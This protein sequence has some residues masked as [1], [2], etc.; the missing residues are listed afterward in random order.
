MDDIVMRYVSSTNSQAKLAKYG[1]DNKNLSAIFQKLSI[2]CGSGAL[3]EV[4]G[5][6]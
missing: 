6:L 3:I 5:I 2:Y 1:P 4:N